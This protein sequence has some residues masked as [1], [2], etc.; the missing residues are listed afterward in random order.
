MERHHLPQGLG[1]R[2]ETAER[3]AGETELMVMCRET[4]LWLS[5]CSS[6][7]D[8]SNPESQSSP[9]G[10]REQSGA[11]LRLANPRRSKL[12]HGSLPCCPTSS[13]KRTTKLHGISREHLNANLG[14]A[15]DHGCLWG[16]GATKGPVGAPNETHTLG[17]GQTWH[18]KMVNMKAG[19]SGIWGYTSHGFQ[20]IRRW[21]IVRHV[22]GT[23]G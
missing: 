6:E 17:E 21:W 12:V 19:G 22:P 11:A 2:L 23:E 9:P 10:P 8:G 5:R 1:R 4:N 13:Q 16:S 20:R 18:N 3:R 14:V 15:S 7:G